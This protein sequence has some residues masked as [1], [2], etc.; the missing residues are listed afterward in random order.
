MSAPASEM[1]LPDG[2]RAQG[3]SPGLRFHRAC[4]CHHLCV[5]RRTKCDISGTPLGRVV[6]TPAI[7]LMAGMTLISPARSHARQNVASRR[8]S[9]SSR[10]RANTWTRRERPLRTSWR[11]NRHGPDPDSHGTRIPLR[12]DSRC[13]TR[14]PIDAQTSTQPG[15]DRRSS[16]GELPL[17]IDLGHGIA[18]GRILLRLTE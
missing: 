5:A 16:A 18:P 4:A 13:S 17:C 2:R 9:S 6:H 14:S 8:R 3:D 10:I 15:R 12:P 11:A 7:S 1:P